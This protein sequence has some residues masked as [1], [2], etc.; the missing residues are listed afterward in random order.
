LFTLPIHILAFEIATDFT[1]APY[2]IRDILGDLEVRAALS[3]IDS[4][5]A[6]GP[7][8]LQSD[9]FL[10]PYMGYSTTTSPTHTRV[11]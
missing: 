3:W 11:D 4:G 5:S 6:T 1:T 9:V 2:Q 7:I 10:I 8:G